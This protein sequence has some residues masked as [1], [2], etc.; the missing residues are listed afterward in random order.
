MKK[1]FYLLMLFLV[2]LT[3]HVEAQDQSIFTLGQKAKNVNHTGDVWLRE[4]N[5]A[6]DHI[7]SQ[8]SVAVFAPKAKLN[9]HSH[10]A[11]QIL[12]IT[13]GKYS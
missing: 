3:H 10:S 9:W 1:I 2:A 12:L 8:I 6:D 13:D 5:A 11:G 4:L 7:N